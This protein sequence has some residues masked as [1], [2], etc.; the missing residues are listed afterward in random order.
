MFTS[1]S[2]SRTARF[3]LAV[4]SFLAAGWLATPAF[5]GNR[6]NEASQQT[7]AALY[8]NYCSVCHGDQGDGNSRAKGSMKPPP[9]DFTTAQSAQE[10][11]RERMIAAVRTGVPGTQTFGGQNQLVVGAPIAPVQLVHG[12]GGHARLV[13]CPDVTRIF[14][15]TRRLSQGVAR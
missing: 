4:L 2:S 7:P 10:M 12:P 9:R 14:F 5:A 11:T 1:S 6:S 15:V 8:H 13:E 3:W